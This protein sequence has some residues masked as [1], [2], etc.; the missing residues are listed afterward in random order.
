MRCHWPSFQSNH[1]HHFYFDQRYVI[2]VSAAEK[3]SCYE[4]G[5]RRRGKKVNCQNGEQFMWNLRY[6]L[7][8]TIITKIH[9]WT[10]AEVRLVAID[11]RVKFSWQH[12]SF[13]TQH[14]NSLTHWNLLLL[15]SWIISEGKLRLL[16]VLVEKEIML[17]QAHLLL[18]VFISVVALVNSYFVL[19]LTCAKASTPTY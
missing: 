17:Y 10:C 5:E 9:T 8:D 7:P 4:T 3:G 6:N 14:V 19:E 15:V 12:K 2:F 1:H 18:H 16:V 13:E 11:S